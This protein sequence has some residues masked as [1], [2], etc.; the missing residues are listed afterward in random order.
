MRALILIGVLVAAAAVI[1]WRGWRLAAVALAGWAVT[2]A[3]LLLDK[4]RVSPVT[5]RV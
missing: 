1:G 2:L 4:W 3:A 5:K